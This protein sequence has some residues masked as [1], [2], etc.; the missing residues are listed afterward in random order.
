M[1]FFPLDAFIIN[2]IL[3]IVNRGFSLKFREIFGACAQ[4][5]V[6][7]K[8][9]MFKI[10]E[11]CSNVK[12]IEGG[13]KVAE[14]RKCEKCVNRYKII[15]NKREKGKRKNI[16][17]LLGIRAKSFGKTEK[18]E[19][20]IYRILFGIKPVAGFKAEKMGRTK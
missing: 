9:F 10:C 8:L 5:Y 14:R 3:L 12:E 15:C 18:R 13:V 1:I 19:R 11:F 20:Q 6:C 17:R 4:R 16:C 7:F 2:G